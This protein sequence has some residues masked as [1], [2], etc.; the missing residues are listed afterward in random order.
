MSQ[1]ARDFIGEAIAVALLVAV[2]I[3]T[4]SVL[5]RSC[6]QT[7]TITCRDGDQ[8]SAES[9]PSSFSISDGFVRSVCGPRGGTV[10][11]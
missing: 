1:G 5:V 7:A 10:E 4:L 8:Y 9:N 6:G 11:R 3:L 2:L